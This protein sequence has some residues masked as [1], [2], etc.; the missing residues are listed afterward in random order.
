MYVFTFSVIRD[1]QAGGRGGGGGMRSLFMYQKS[2][3]RFFFCVWGDLLIFR[4]TE[5]E[6]ES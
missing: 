4:I 3:I 1:S 6:D 5:V 2:R